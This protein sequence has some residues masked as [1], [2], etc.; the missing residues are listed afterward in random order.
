MTSEQVAWITG[1]SSGIGRALALRLACDGWSVV[2]SA[3]R[4][5]ELAALAAESNDF[6]G[7]IVPMPLDV[8]DLEETR[9]AV[10]RIEA[11]YGP[12]SLAVLCAGIYERD[13]AA[14]FD[15][16]A[17]EKQIRINLMGA[18]HALETVMSGMIDRG[19]GHIAVVSSVA[20]Y[21]G[22]PGAAA[23][24]AS[25]AALIAMAESLRP[26]LAGHGVKLQVVSPGF[27]RT[28]LTDR[29]DFPM[30]FLMELDDAVAAF[31]RG[32]SA[33]RFEIS[34]P[35]RFAMLMKLL[36]VLPDRLFFVITRSMV[37]SP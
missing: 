28:P 22:L 36:R 13:S 5:A 12:I 14:G 33:R 25:K 30:P 37:R 3:R 19:A 27:V 26:E 29:N 24:G 7:R 9:E 23:Y 6:A 4:A 1:A 8:T 32:L 15:A 35:W 11:K 31:H 16:A 2:A 10:R 34:F 17:F 21:R 18:V 20:G